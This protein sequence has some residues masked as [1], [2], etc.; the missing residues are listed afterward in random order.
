MQT[1]GISTKSFILLR[2]LP[3]FLTMRR[4]LPGIVLFAFSVIFFAGVMKTTRREASLLLVNG[5]VYTLDPDHRV[6]E[7]VAIRGDQIVGV[8]KS[9]ELTEKFRADSVTDLR[10]KTVMPG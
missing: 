6:T 5:T 2:L 10:G 7:A 1:L 9:D 8:G 3:N 4:A